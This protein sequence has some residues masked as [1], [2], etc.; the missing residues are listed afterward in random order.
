MPNLSV[1]L[2]LFNKRS[3]QKLNNCDAWWTV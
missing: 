1:S 2:T 3:N